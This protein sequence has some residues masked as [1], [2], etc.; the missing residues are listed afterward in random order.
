M[1]RHCS[2]SRPR[3]GDRGAGA[4]SPGSEGGG[5]DLATPQQPQQEQPSRSTNLLDDTASSIGLGNMFSRELHLKSALN[6]VA[7]Q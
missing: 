4:R 2:R 7:D 6:T 1:D 3:R 5:T